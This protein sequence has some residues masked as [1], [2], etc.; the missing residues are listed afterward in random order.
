[1]VR[2]LLQ[3]C[4]EVFIVGRWMSEADVCSL[5]NLLLHSP[6]WCVLLSNKDSVVF[7][8]I[9]V[10][11]LKISIRLLRSRYYSSVGVGVVGGVLCNCCCCICQWSWSN[12]SYCLFNKVC[13]LLFFDPLGH[14]SASFYFFLLA[15]KTRINVHYSLR[16]AAVLLLKLRLRLAFIRTVFT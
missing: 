6:S 5:P 15:A 1:M 8:G 12:R 2:I 10:P 4:P 14:S 9:L 7:V 16:A 3:Y 11:F 13:M